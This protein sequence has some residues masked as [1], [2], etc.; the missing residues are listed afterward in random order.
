MTTAE[1]VHCPPSET[2][3]LERTRFFPRQLVTPDDLTQDQ[4]YFRD[5]LRRHNRFLH[6]WGVV[7]GAWVRKH[8]DPGKVV[9][10]PGYVLGPW[11]DEIVIDKEV[12]VDLF[13][14]TTEGL[15]HATCTDPA[16]PWCSRVR[17]ERRAGATSYLAVRYDECDT[18]PVRVATDACGCDLTEC[19]YSR[20][21]D[22]Y[23]VKLLSALPASYTATPARP[24][25]TTSTEQRC[26]ELNMPIGEPD[27]TVVVEGITLEN[28]GEN[29]IAVVTRD[30]FIGLGFNQTLRVTLPEPTARV[31]FTLR[32]AHDKVRAQSTHQDGST[33][34]ESLP[35]TSAN[36]QPQGFT[37]TGTG[38]TGLLITTKGGLLL[39]LC[40]DA[41]VERPQGPKEEGRPCPR[42]PEDP[43]VI[44]ADVTFAGGG[45]VDAVDPEKHRRWVT[46]FAG[47]ETVG[48]AP[49]GGATTGG[50]AA[51]GGGMITLA[52]DVPPRGGFTGRFDA[53]VLENLLDRRWIRRWESEHGAQPAA[54]GTLPATALQGISARSELGRAVANMKIADITALSRDEFVATV[55]RAVP[56]SADREDLERRAT[57]LWERARKVLGRG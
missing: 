40:Y 7:C 39:D 8:A 54:L 52:P 3:A 34:V 6:G 53:R 23:A 30:G 1:L 28:V 42:C 20:T 55:R 31:T 22:G 19:Q 14:E 41:R 43:W 51:G 21:R 26:I 48:A 49:S 16:D 46:S 37:I 4:R 2:P 25:T 50:G 12:P 44:L 5:K 45:R 56:R 38:I 24:G 29:S 27:S 15:V 13:Q 57:E 17:V 33:R 18:R 35:S 9:I 32:H 47:R 10:E 36:P 11:G